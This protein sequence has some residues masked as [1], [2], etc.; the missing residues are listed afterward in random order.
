MA[1]FKRTVRDGNGS[2]VPLADLYVRNELNTALV[3]IYSDAAMTTAI[4]QPQVSDSD[5]AVT[6]YVPPG[7]YT[8]TAQ[9]GG[10]EWVEVVKI[11]PQRVYA[12]PAALIASTE[13]SRKEGAFWT[14][15]DGFI[16]E[17][18]ATSAS[19]HHLT[20]AGGVKLY[21]LPNTSGDLSVVACG[22]VRDGVS[23]TVGTDNA[24]A[25]QIAFST[26]YP[27]IIDAGAYR[28]SSVTIA[29]Q[30]SIKGA[31]MGETIIYP[32]TGNSCFIIATDHVEI[33]DLEFRG[34]TGSGQAEVTG[35]CILCDAVSNN[36]A[37]T[38]PME[39]V[40]IERVK[41]R[42]LKM[43]GIHMAQP[44]RESVI[45]NC[46][47]IGMGDP[48][49]GASPIK[50]RQTLG[51]ASTI[52]NIWVEG[53]VF[54]GFGTPAINF[55]RSTL[56]ASSAQASYA[57]LYIVGNLIHGQ[58]L[59]ESSGVEAVQPEECHQVLIQDVTDLWCAG[60]KFT[61][62]HPEF[63]ALRIVNNGTACD[64]SRVI[65]NTYAV[66]TPVAGVTYS[67][68]IGNATGE[69]VFMQGAH[70]FVLTGNTMNGN[71]FNN[72]F[73]LD[74]GSLTGVNLYV[75]GNVT[76]NGAEIIIDTTGMGAWIGRVATNESY[77][78]RR[79][80][81]HRDDLNV[82][83]V[84]PRV[85][86]IYDLGTSALRFDRAFVRTLR[87]GPSGAQSWTSG[88]GSPEGVLSAT[89]GSLYTQTDGGAG[90]TLY[91]K[92]TGSGTTGWVAK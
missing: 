81:T 89:V 60:N 54:Y 3:T 4:T 10:D 41:F 91:V 34:Q 92:E 11:D 83:E 6:F 78:E 29:Q 90:T 69:F 44:L 30:K 61:S 8:L 16:Y 71:V 64:A 28:V 56:I 88:S 84:I 26:D 73:T 5:G 47:F 50:G 12:D 85:T 1:L 9:R 63:S 2:I 79:S 14:T 74:Q 32:V 42:K 24:A 45:R 37:F 53:N 15:Q 22:A 86:D 58:L 31:G 19:D 35:D 13:V 49:S 38:R 77:D 66:A 80:G 40:K 72:D 68:G 82:Q 55:E 46:R 67:R 59:D 20:T 52:N 43:N 48:T 17:E 75:D 39:G 57:T 65:G 21:V 62:S 70:G 51:I 76:S 27:V 25:F 23:P 7:V 36:A 33:S 87:V 18:A